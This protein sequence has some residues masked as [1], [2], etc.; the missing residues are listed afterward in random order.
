MKFEKEGDF[1]GREALSAAAE[2]ALEN[3]RGCSS[4]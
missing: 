3:P 2:R 4:A 1:V